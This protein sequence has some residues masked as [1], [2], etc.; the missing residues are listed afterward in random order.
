MGKPLAQDIRLLALAI[1]T[2]GYS[3]ADLVDLCDLAIERALHDSLTTKKR[4]QICMNDFIIA[5]K[6]RKSS[7]AEWFTLAQRELKNDIAFFKEIF[8]YGQK[9]KNGV[10]V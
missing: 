9:F 4:R 10:A 5:L 3:G 1:E 7:V 2:E 6:G 8:E